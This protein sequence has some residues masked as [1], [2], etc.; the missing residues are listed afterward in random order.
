[1]RAL[2][3][4]VSLSREIDVPLRVYWMKVH[5]LNCSFSDLFD[6]TPEYEVVEKTAP[7][8]CDA[9]SKEYLFDPRTYRILSKREWHILN[10]FNVKELIGQQFDFRLLK[11]HRQILMAT[12]TRF[13]PSNRM[14]SIFVPLAFLRQRID[15]ECERF[16]PNTTG[17][18][19]RRTDHRWAINNSPTE[20]FI[21]AIENEIKWRPDV[22]FYLASDCIETKR[23]L[24]GRY[25]D[26]IITSFHASDRTT[27][28]GIRQALVELY[29]LSRTQKIYGSYC[30]T[31]SE[32]A[33][34]I[35]GIHEI[36]VSN[37][38][39][40]AVHIS[41]AENL[42]TKALQMPL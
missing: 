31:F 19:I 17:I 25:G 4:A 36:T 32:T 8:V 28:E 20:L 37:I 18:H 7:F 9:A 10:N 23:L 5:N 14:N 13:Y 26:R 22:S 41:I 15:R 3:S 29:A 16:Q 39:H 6:P 2:D 42:P 11:H 33:A 35:G 30:S 24:H 34:N 40:S 38:I 12:N 27:K 21:R 1:M